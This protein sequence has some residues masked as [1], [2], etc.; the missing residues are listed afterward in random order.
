M[1]KN[2]WHEKTAYQIYPK[3]FCDSNGDGIGDLKGIITD[4]QALLQ[5]AAIG[6]GKRILLFLAA[7]IFLQAQ[8]V[9][10]EDSSF[11]VACVGDSITRGFRLENPD[12][13]SYPAVLEGLLGEGYEVKNFGRSGASLIH[14]GNCYGRYPE[15]HQSLEAQADAYLIMLGTNDCYGGIWNPEEYEVYLGNMVD[16]Y[17]KENEDTEIYLMVPPHVFGEREDLQ[18]I[19]P[20]IE[21]ELYGIVER[22]AEEKETGFIDLFTP[23]DGKDDLFPDGVHPNQ[24]GH[25]LLAEL[26]YD[27]LGLTQ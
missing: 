21:G 5:K 27:E 13:D 12:K 19:N 25:Q 2:W 8:P 17:R 15:Y 11:C 20:L 16:A 1:N 7:F 6:N 22:V 4:E 9:R 24:E 26:V 3:S 14:E 23:T 18:E 10:A